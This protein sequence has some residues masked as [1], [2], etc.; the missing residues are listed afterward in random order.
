M[1]LKL[2]SEGTIDDGEIARDLGQEPA[3]IVILSAADSDLATF[4]AAWRQ[5]PAGFPSLRLT[6]LLALGHP[7]SVD[8]YVERTLKTAKIVI[9]RM[10][11]GEAYWPYGVES[12]RSDAAR[13]K[14]LLAV[15]PGE[16]TWD[17]ALAA[18]GNVTPEA[19]ETLWRYCSEGGV[20]NAIGALKFAAHVIGH[21]DAPPPPKP[22]PAAGFWRSPAAGPQPNV[23]IIFYRAL[24]ASGDTAPIEALV[25]TL[26]ESGLKPLP[27]FVTSLKDA[28]S[29]AFLGTA[30]AAYP[31]E[32]IVN[33]TAFATAT[34]NDLDDLATR[35]SEG[36]LIHR[37]GPV[38]MPEFT[39]TPQ[40]IAD[41]IAY[42][43]SLREG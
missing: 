6:N 34:T 2:A 33:A 43:K 14:S 25:D 7:A 29:I 19:A 1:H 42:M 37:P 12:L 27:I 24:A 41:L 30:L 23:P 38:A 18:R 11:G 35:F 31:P 36:R 21:G 13:R 40:E 9:L 8:A 20:E 3:D 16:L 39:F 15:L 26:D 5:L 4:A 32:L 28:R 22:M 10:L 17:A